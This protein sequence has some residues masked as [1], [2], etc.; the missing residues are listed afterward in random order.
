MKKALLLTFIILLLIGVA[1][2]LFAFRS[3]PSIRVRVL[4]V[5]GEPVPGAT[6]KPYA[7]RG[8]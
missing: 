8:E 6:L 5:A 1:V 7:L 4:D 2:L 3:A